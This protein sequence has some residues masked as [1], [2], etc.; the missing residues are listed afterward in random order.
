L[1]LVLCI[2]GT[3]AVATLPRSLIDRAFSLAMFVYSLDLG[4]FVISPNRYSVGRI[5]ARV[6]I[7]LGSASVLAYL[8]RGL[9]LDRLRL[10]LTQREL[11]TS[12]AESTLRA[13]Q[14]R[15]LWQAVTVD[16]LPDREFFQTITD[17]GSANLRPGHGIY[18][19]VSQFFN[20]E[21]I[22][23]ASS[24]GGA[25]YAVEGAEAGPKIS[26]G[27]NIERQL[28][29]AGR[30]TIFEATGE[31][32][33]VWKSAIGTPIMMGGAV[34]F[35]VFASTEDLHEK[36]FVESDVGFVE[37]LGSQISH[38]YY[39]QDQYARL[40]YQLEHDSLTGLFN[41]AQLRKELRRAIVPKSRPLW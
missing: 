17:L 13:A 24:F 36:P 41:F 4:L 30:T 16:Q 18:G 29:E 12:T 20:D 9:L 25:L 7:V 38:R 31:Q 14:F 40:R 5:V 34:H 19:Y 26:S 3:I 2:F 32:P 33:D 11:Q 21:L 27:G 37:V 22:I 35:L 39:Q 23:E 15:A 28:K 1:E 8:M 10:L 6:L